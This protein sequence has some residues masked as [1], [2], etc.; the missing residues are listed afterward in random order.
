M[1]SNQGRQILELLTDIS[2]PDL[3]EA[4]K[5]M[6]LEIGRHPS[7]ASCECPMIEGLALLYERGYKLV[8][9]EGDSV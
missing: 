1:P 6:W 8:P 9:V 4:T 7:V 2:C 3:A 5:A